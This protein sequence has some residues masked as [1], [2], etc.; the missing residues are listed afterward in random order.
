MAV[1]PI[2]IFCAS[3]IVSGSLLATL[4]VDAAT[5]NPGSTMSKKE[6]NPSIDIIN[7]QEQAQR[8][9]RELVAAVRL[10]RNEGVRWR[11]IARTLDLPPEE[12]RARFDR[13]DEGHQDP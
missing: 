10:A 12:V 6:N 2:R 5:T 9:D 7:R 4:P 8:A 11:E 13:P 1:T 3:L